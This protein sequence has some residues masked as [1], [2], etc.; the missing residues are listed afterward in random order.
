M[1]TEMLWHRLD[2]TVV[3]FDNVYRIPDGLQHN[4]ICNICAKEAEYA[5]LESRDKLVALYC[6]DHIFQARRGK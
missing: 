5:K 3:F 6:G 2:H 4:Y 1:T